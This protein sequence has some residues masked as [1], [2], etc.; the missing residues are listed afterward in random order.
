MQ[1]SV[2]QGNTDGKEGAVSSVLPLGPKIK[3]GKVLKTSKESK[4]NMTNKREGMTGNGYQTFNS[5]FIPFSNQTNHN[6][7][8][9][10]GEGRVENG[11]QTFHS[12]S[13]PLS[14][15]TNGNIYSNKRD[16]MRE[17]GSQTLNS[18]S[19]PLS[20]KTNSNIHSNKGEGMRG[21]GPQTFHSL[22]I[23][24][25]NKTKL[26]NTKQIKSGEDY[27]VEDYKND[28]DTSNMDEYS[29]A[30]KPKHFSLHYRKDIE[31][32]ELRDTESMN[33]KNK[34]TSLR[35]G[36]PRQLKAKVFV[37]SSSEESDQKE[38][39][40]VASTTQK[41]M[42]KDE[43]R[44][45]SKIKK[46]TNQAGTKLGKEKTNVEGKKQ[47]EDDEPETGDAKGIKP[48][49]LWR[50]GSPGFWKFIRPI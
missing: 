9:N 4:E 27:A 21:N 45:I 47:S 10:K 34:N 37:L 33:T 25:S 35:D 38:L 42:N 43:S 49:I 14:N 36:E 18:L 1:K 29:I 13:I 44:K 11:S 40:K 41:I 24:K 50:G 2:T 17:N 32:N 48:W 8:S 16:G 20:K 30:F 12:L 7:Y 23:P 46:S 39:S 26:S 15:Q 6:K 28:Y 19:I 31:S 22:S 3:G 5:L